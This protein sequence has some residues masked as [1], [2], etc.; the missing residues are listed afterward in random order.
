MYLKSYEIAP[1]R[2]KYKN[3]SVH[4]KFGNNEQFRKKMGRYEE[5]VAVLKLHDETFKRFSKYNL[6]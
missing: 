3:I 2:A 4:D 5:P 1:T 6:G